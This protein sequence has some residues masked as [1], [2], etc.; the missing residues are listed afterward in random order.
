MTP[1]VP[2]DDECR[3]KSILLKQKRPAHRLFYHQMLTF[4]CAFLSPFFALVSAFGAL[5]GV[6]TRHTHHACSFPSRPPPFCFLFLFCFHIYVLLLG[7]YRHWL[8]CRHISPSHSFSF[9]PPPAPLPPSLLPRLPTPPSTYPSILPL[10]PT[11]LSPHEAA[12]FRNTFGVPPIP[13]PTTAAEAGG[14]ISFTPFG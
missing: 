6:A 5:V 13:L 11:Q 7:F 1:A 10:I 2:N 4:H 9:P 12:T 14:S 3:P 8:P